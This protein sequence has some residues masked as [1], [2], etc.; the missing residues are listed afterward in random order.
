MVR[1]AKEVKLLL[2]SLVLIG[3]CGCTATSGQSS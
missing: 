2:I 3:L 1:P